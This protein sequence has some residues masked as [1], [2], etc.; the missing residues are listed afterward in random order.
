M[1]IAFVTRADTFSANSAFQICNLLVL[2]KFVPHTHGYLIPIRLK[3]L[4]GKTFFLEGGGGPLY[5][6]RHLTMA[7]NPKLRKKQTH[8]P[9]RADI[10]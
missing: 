6:E 1:Q 9:Q 4:T 7:P 5:T 2:L 3:N 8:C 10:M